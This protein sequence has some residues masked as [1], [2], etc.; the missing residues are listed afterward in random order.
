MKKELTRSELEALYLPPAGEL[1][2]VD[3]PDMPFLM[4]DGD[5]SP[6]ADPFQRALRWLFRVVHPIRREARARM[7]GHFVEP[8]LQGLWWAEDVADLVAGK[9][10]EMRWRLMIPVPEW[11]TDDLFTEAIRDVAAKHGDLPEDLRLERYHEGESIQILHVGPDEEISDV[12][13]GLYEHLHERGLAPSGPHH[14]IYLTDP[15]RTP[16]AKRRTLLR[17]PVRPE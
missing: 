6:D 14:Q 5:G 12:A 9:K 13:R 11:V 10:D 3:V 15:A 1:V 16:P 4:I 7:G 8:P 2:V 17:Q